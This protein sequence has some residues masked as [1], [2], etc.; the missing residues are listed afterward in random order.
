MNLIITHLSESYHFYN[1]YMG[2]EYKMNNVLKI[3]YK[4]FSEDI[5]KDYHDN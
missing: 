2:E 3:T 4:L 1:I 5:Y